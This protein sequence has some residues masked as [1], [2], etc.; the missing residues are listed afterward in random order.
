M[1]ERAGV[2]ANRTLA[3]RG[4]SYPRIALTRARAG[5]AYEAAGVTAP[6]ESDKREKKTPRG[7]VMRPHRER[8]EHL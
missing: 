1:S 7:L 3:A 4:R 5:G 8:D 6:R 2:K